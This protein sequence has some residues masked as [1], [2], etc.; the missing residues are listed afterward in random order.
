[1]ETSPTAASTRHLTER[2]LD[3]VQRGTGEDLGQRSA[4]AAAPAGCSWEGLAAY[5]ADQLRERAAGRGPNRLPSVEAAYGAYKAGILAQ[6]LDN[7][8]YVVKH[9]LWRS[10]ETWRGGA[11][12]EPNLVP[13]HLAAGISHWVLW[14]HPD[15][16]AGDTELDPAA[17]LALVRALLGQEAPRED[18]ALVFQN[19]PAHR[20]IGTI[21]HSHVFLRPSTADE[22]GRRLAR[23]L[24][25]EHDA[26][27]ARS[28]WLAGERRE[29][30]L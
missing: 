10:G 20:S 2:A 7:H 18:E 23:R 5:K 28:P 27:R 9:A 6:G 11:A 15:G 14:H 4:R 17:E 19:V 16:V 8:G 30:E 26:W 3:A 25:A 1:M 29:G 13:Y 22:A 21:A 12:L 24:E